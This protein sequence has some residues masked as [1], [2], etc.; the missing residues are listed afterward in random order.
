MTAPV[1]SALVRLGALLG[2]SALRV[3][4]AL[5]T[6]TSVTAAVAGP[7]AYQAHEARERTRRDRRGRGTRTQEEGVGGGTI[8]RQSDH[9][10][11]ADHD[12][13]A[14]DHLGVH[15]HLGIRPPPWLPRRPGPRFRPPRPPGDH[16]A[17]HVADG[18]HLLELPGEPSTTV[19]PAQPASGIT[20]VRDRGRAV[21]G[22]S[23]V[24]PC[25]AR[26]S[27]GSTPGSSRVIRSVLSPSMRP[28]RRQRSE[29]A[30]RHL[31]ARERQQ[32]QVQRRGD[33]AARRPRSRLGFVHRQQRTDQQL[34]TAR[35]PFSSSTREGALQP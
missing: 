3:G 1:T 30:T 35:P 25:P 4:I 5:V 20:F 21:P 7:M 33:H 13:G 6:A 29:L 23:R 26:C 32:P 34:L 11:R 24:R 31:R 18:A 9:D 22:P 17:G 12:L 16:C 14:H 2:G 28:T 19:P 15:D 10:D 8:P 27:S